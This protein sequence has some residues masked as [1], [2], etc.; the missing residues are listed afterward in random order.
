MLVRGSSSFSVLHKACCA[1]SSC[2]TLTGEHVPWRPLDK[3]RGGFADRAVRL[4]HLCHHFSS[5][6]FSIVI[7]IFVPTIS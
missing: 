4:G 7:P 1:V 6:V 2:V 5:P 3:G